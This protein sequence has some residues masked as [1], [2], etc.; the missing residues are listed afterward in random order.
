MEASWDRTISIYTRYWT[1]PEGWIGKD[2]NWGDLKF[3]YQSILCIL[4]RCEAVMLH[5][6]HIGLIIKYHGY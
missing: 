3:D 1:K 5:T 6:K 4:L 2:V